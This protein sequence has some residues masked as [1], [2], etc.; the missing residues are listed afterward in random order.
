MAL[1]AINISA[2]LHERLRREAFE[3]NTSMAK[4]AEHY[5]GGGLSAK[6]MAAEPIKDFPEGGFFESNLPPIEVPE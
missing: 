4:L 6:P 1:K 5:I 2:E 3:K